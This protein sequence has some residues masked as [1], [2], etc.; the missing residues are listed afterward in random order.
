MCSDLQHAL[1]HVKDS[2]IKHKW[3]LTA[4][5]IWIF[6]CS[7]WTAYDQ[8]N[9]YKLYGLSASAADYIIAQQ[10]A[11]YS[12][13]TIFPFVLFFV[14]K[15]KQNSLNTQYILRYQS[16]KR[17]LKNQF[18]ESVMYA[19]ISAL[20]LVGIATMIGWT[21]SGKLINWDALDSVFIGQTGESVK[22]NFLAV[23]VIAWLMYTLKF[24]ILFAVADIAMWFPK[25]LFLVWIVLLLPLG[26]EALH[27][28]NIFFNLF[29][30]RQTLW[31]SPGKWSALIISGVIIFGLEYMAGKKL[32]K[33]RDIWG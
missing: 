9:M 15:C 11:L 7:F 6:V 27:Y 23:A 33:K 5:V 32:V 26:I 28:G 17:M 16:R 2:V 18:I 20:L 29:A 21:V 30:I 4:A 13:L 19:V 24:S 3:I 25:T 14:I 1:R 22:V 12:G 10:E 31:M 8:E